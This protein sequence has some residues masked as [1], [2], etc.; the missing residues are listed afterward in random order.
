[1]RPLTGLSDDRLV[2]L[3]RAGR[4]DAFDALYDR[5]RLRLVRFA[6][7]ILSGAADEA[8]DVVQDAFLR[9]HRALRATDRAIVLGPW[10]YTIVRN[11]ALDAR[12]A[13]TRVREPPGRQP[14]ALPSTD[15]PERSLEQ[16]DCLRRVVNQLGQLP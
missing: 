11:R 16:R 5:Y 15:D 6:R 8:E 1:M 4:E 9:A 10:L 14:V 12:R 13:R 2:D 7:R 3:F